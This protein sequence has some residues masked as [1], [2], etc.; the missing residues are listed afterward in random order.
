MHVALQIGRDERELVVD[1][2]FGLEDLGF[3][4]VRDEIGIMDSLIPDVEEVRGRAKL[5]R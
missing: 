2:R 4:V 1:G 3:G 5:E